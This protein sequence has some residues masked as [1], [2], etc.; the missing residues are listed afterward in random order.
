[1]RDRLLLG[2]VL[3][4]LLIGGLWL[5]QR[6]PALDLGVNLLGHTRPPRGTIIFAVMVLLAVLGS[7]EMAAIL[8]ANGV[9]AS[10]RIMTFAAILGLLASCVIPWGAPGPPAAAAVSTAAV[11]VM[12]VALAF[13]SRHKSV[14]GVVAATGGALLSFVYLG[15]MFG[16]VLALRREHSAWVL[17]WV[18]LVTKACDIGAYFTGKAV[19]RHKLIPWLSPGK[20]WEGL[21]GGVVL[22]CGVCI[23]GAWALRAWTSAV[24]P[25]IGWL[26]ATGAAFA[27]I[28]QAGDLLESL[29]KRDAGMK[30]SG[31]SL[32]GFGGVLDVLDSP[33][34]VAPAA[35]WA[36]RAFAQTG[37]L[38]E[39][40]A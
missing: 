4:A 19:G 1:M 17:L 20:T 30:D 7:R 29:F 36:L 33:L 14:E 24:T 21:A 11:I 23:A 25:P 38:V 34:L 32:P 31:K 39:S 27:V 3:I 22:S 37:L 28:G 6:L 9:T 18:L 35:Y 13:Y 15:L 40:A 2:P 12:V 5:D 26:I 10:K 16:F 8:A